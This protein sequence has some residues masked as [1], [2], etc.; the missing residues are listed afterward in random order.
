MATKLVF[1]CRAHER[2]RKIGLDPRNRIAFVSDKR[3]ERIAITDGIR[4]ALA[5]CCGYCDQDEKKCALSSARH[6]QGY[7]VLEKVSFI[8]LVLLSEPERAATRAPR[9][10]Q[11]DQLELLLPFAGDKVV[12][13]KG[14]FI[15]PNIM[16][17]G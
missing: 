3:G 15:D 8:R 6:P 7:S 10:T 5:R 12:P 13:R 16:V 14:D 11:K 17:I 4:V 9:R 2:N 1:P